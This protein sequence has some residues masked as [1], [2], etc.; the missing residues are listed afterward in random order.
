M[1]SNTQIIRGEI[2]VI[3]DEPAIRRLLRLALEAEDYS[4]NTADCGKAGLVEAARRPPDLVI[5]DL[6]LPDMDGLEVLKRLREW[7]TSPVLV[8]SV[9]QDVQDK[10]MALD[11]GAD[12]YLTKPFSPRELVLRIRKILERGKPAGEKH[13]AIQVPTSVSSGAC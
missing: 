3:D 2:L 1:T 10:V 4:V 7:C 11:F 8:L 12:D 9:R 5:L 6:G 13:E